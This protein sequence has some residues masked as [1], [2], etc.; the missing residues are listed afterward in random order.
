MDLSVMNLSFGPSFSDY[1]IL[2]ATGL[3]GATL[4]LDT[5]TAQSIETS[6]P[7]FRFL[8]FAAT[9]QNCSFTGVSATTVLLFVS[10]SNA[11]ILY[12][13]FINNTATINGGIQIHICRQY[14]TLPGG[15]TVNTGSL[16]VDYSYFAGNA[17][18]SSGGAIYVSAPSGGV[19]VQN[20]IFINNKAA[21]QVNMHSVVS[22]L[23][24]REVQFM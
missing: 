5:L 23:C 13:T 11:T 16:V 21:T 22:G 3:T 14:L 1:M 18:G 4:L 12:C 17:V 15:V 20:S 24:F 7:L 9:V 6:G 2:S 10:Q 8:T 19:T